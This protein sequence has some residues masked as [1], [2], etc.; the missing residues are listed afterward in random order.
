MDPF[1]GGS[2]ALLPKTKRSAECKGG[3]RTID[4]NDYLELPE[5]RALPTVKGTYRYL[6]ICWICLRTGN[7]CQYGERMHKKQICRHLLVKMKR[8]IQYTTRTGQNTGRSNISNQ[9]QMNPI[10]MALVAAY[11]NLNSGS[12]RTK[13]LN[14]CVSLV[15][16][17][18]AAP[19]SMSSSCSNDGSNFGEMKARKRLRR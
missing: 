13:G 7:G 12:L 6:I 14:S 18:P 8:M 17:P 15:G 4:R 2:P 10:A 1:A 5:Y 9:L 3:C 19:S 11:Q 16:N